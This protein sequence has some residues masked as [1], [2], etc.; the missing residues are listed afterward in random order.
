MTRA[1]TLVG[2]PALA[3]ALV[4]AGQS[5]GA[6]AGVASWHVDRSFG[7]RGVA[8]L[9]VRESAPYPLP[10]GPGD[11]GSLLTDGPQGSVFV[12]GY[13]RSERGSFLIARLSAQ[14]RLVRGFGHGG[15]TTVPAIY[16]VPQEPPRM[17]A[18]SGG[19]LLIAGL[20]RTDHFVLVRLTAG[21]KADRSFG[22]DGV[23][24]YR[25]PDSRGHAI[26]AAAALQP[27]GDILAVSFQR[28]VP[29][30]LNEPQVPPGLGEG[31]IEF[32]RLLPSGALDRSF[33]DGG[34]LKASRR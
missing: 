10:L 30:P 20:D 5:A 28:E 18:L 32:V 8:V 6:T 31:P 17:L 26:I 4:I 11:A 23:A 33:G 1:K 34:F 22:H 13:A 24:A 3:L 7:K 19:R 25:L 16:S 15:V 14:G 21:G 12:G 27:D 2:C 29:E 9:P